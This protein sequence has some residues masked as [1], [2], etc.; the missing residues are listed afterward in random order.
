[1][2]RSRLDMNTASDST[3]TTAVARR[4]SVPF[5]VAVTVAG[6]VTLTGFSS[7]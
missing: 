6:G 4:A 2:N 1:M 3:P 5:S 7:T